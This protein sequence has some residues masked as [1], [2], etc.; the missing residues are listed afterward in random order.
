[1][2]QLNPGGINLTNLVINLDKI[3]KFS[4]IKHSI[5][6]ISLIILLFLLPFFI[7]YVPNYSPYRS[8]NNQEDYGHSNLAN[9]LSSDY[10]VDRLTGDLND[11]GS[12]IARDNIL[13]IIA[14]ENKY[15]SDDIE[16]L[17]NWINRGGGILIVG[18]NEET[19]GLAN[20][21]N[22]FYD[23]FS[24]KIFD[25]INNFND[26]ASMP[27]VYG[28]DGKEYYAVVPITVIHYS[29]NSLYTDVIQT[30]NS[31][32]TAQCI[33][34]NMECKDLSYTI[35]ITHL[36][37][38]VIKDSQVSILSDNW[39]FSNIYTDL[40]PENINLFHEIINRMNPNANQ[41]IFEETHY[42]Y[43]PVNRIGIEN[44]VNKTFT[45]NVINILLV[46][47]TI[48]LPLGLGTNGGIFSNIGQ[49]LFSN[50]I[51]RR[52]GERLESLHLE[53]V[54]AVV[55]TKEEKFLVDMQL[56]MQRR[57]KH[58]F[59]LIALDLLNYIKQEELEIPTNSIEDLKSMEEYIIQPDHCW[60]LILRVNEEIKIAEKAKKNIL[61]GK[62]L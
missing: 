6:V 3:N 26:T 30:D 34:N 38:K 32:K 53:N 61:G 16:L 4:K 58:F 15:K 29:D 22:Y 50:K 33:R 14:P 27:L 17:D 11:L 13:V 51:G 20:Y 12:I 43:A 28:P 21:Y 23:D 60:R 62:I 55:M 2:I 45:S 1:M 54:T 56:S 39:M 10:Q 46:I 31:A 18:T 25:E 8:I 7:E 44:I 24:G 49:V 42:N 41:I 37:S 47:F 19:I 59:K 40:V 52:L 35:G 9:N 48:V 5:I 57:G 36:S